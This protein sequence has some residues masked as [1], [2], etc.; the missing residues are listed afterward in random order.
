MKRVINKFF[1]FIGSIIFFIGFL[2]CVKAAG[3]C[4]MDGSIDLMARY[5]AAGTIT[6]IFGLFI[7]RWRI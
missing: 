6:A 2:M 3:I 7:H 5:S 4:D 1:C